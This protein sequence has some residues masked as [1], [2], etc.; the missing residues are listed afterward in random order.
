ME[1]GF[2]LISYSTDI[3]IYGAGLVSELNAVR[4]IASEG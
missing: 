1:I 3:G 4:A 2:N